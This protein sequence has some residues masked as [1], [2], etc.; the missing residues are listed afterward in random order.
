MRFDGEMIQR[1]RR[2]VECEGIQ[3]PDVEPARKCMFRAD[4]GGLGVPPAQPLLRVIGS[5]EE[6]SHLLD[7]R[8]SLTKAADFED[9]LEAFP[10]IADIVLHK[11]FYGQHAHGYHVSLDRRTEDIRNEAHVSCWHQL[12]KA[13]DLSRLFRTNSVRD[14]VEKKFWCIVETDPARISAGIWG[15]ETETR[16]P[17]YIDFSRVRYIRDESEPLAKLFNDNMPSVTYPQLFCKR[18]NWSWE[19]EARLVMHDWGVATTTPG[20]RAVRGLPPLPRWIYAAID[21]RALIERI[22]FTKKEFADF[23]YRTCPALG[24]GQDIRVEGQDVVIECLM[25]KAI[26][27]P[28]FPDLLPEQ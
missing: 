10:T 7:G 11:Q 23:A 15:T 12:T 5:I 8:L 2:D 21:P 16:E 26:D 18:S 27:P 24:A 4:L 19:N 6:F 13:S 20:P 1:K 14:G 22:W 28:P 9:K 3:M 17:W 25:G